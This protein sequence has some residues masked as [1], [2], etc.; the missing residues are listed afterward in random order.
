MFSRNK[1]PIQQDPNVLDLST[2]EL[3]PTRNTG[4]NLPDKRVKE[5]GF[6]VMASQDVLNIHNESYAV[7][8]STYNSVV[9]S[10]NRKEEAG[11]VNILAM[12]ARSKG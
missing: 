3:E 2:L 5:N 9:D 11:K 7:P 8:N 4:C 12:R 6:L 10:K 1:K